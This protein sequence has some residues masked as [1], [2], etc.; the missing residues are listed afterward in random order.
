MV[1]RA[2][3]ARKQAEDLVKRRDTTGGVEKRFDQADS[4]YALAHVA[5]R[6]WAEPLIGRAWVAYRRSRLVNFDAVAARPWIDKGEK[7][8]NDALKLD[9]QNPD[10]LEARGTLRYWKWILALEP[11]AT[12]AKKLLATAQS[13]LET[14]VKVRPTQAGAWAMLSH[15]YNQTSG[16]TDAKLA[17]RRA[18]EADAYLSN[19]DVILSRLYLASYDLAQFV[20]AAHW[21]DEGQRRF[22]NDFKFVRCQLWLMTSKAREPDV[23][24]AWR[25]A[26]SLPKVVPAPER[27]YYKLEGQIATAA[28]LARA[29]LADSARQLLR[30]SRGGVEVDPDRQLLVMEGFV[31][32][33]L[34]DKDEALKT[35]K[36]FL[37]ANPA[38]RAGL[39]EDPG[40]WY[41]SL[42]DD[43]RFL[44]LVTAR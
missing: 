5:D 43:P 13:D 23:A 29:G 20:D 6:G 31:H 27:G 39:A 37:A 26:D 38:R 19:A 22:P 40:W 14:A 35:L 11:D 21:C 8:A 16:E 25:L 10:A 18:Y 32:L 30:R 2:E 9:P 3:Q 4:N 41:R 12:A 17:A 42:Q 15:L 7:L 44:A 1:Q 36:A 34:G 24:L 33:L 28:V